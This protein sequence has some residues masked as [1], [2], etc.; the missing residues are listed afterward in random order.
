VFV[1]SLFLANSLCLG[2]KL[3][4]SHKTRALAYTE[5]AVSDL[6]PNPVFTSSNFD[7]CIK[8][9]IGQKPVL[10][11]WSISPAQPGARRNITFAAQFPTASGWMGLG[12]SASGSMIGAD[13]ITV[14][15]VGSSWIAEDRF[16]SAAELPQLDS[17]QDVMLVGASSAGGQSF[18]Q[19]VR[20]LVY[21]DGDLQDISVGDN[22]VP[23]ILAYGADGSYDFLYHGF[24]RRGSVWLNL[25]QKPSPT[26]SPPDGASIM[27]VRHTNL[28]V[29]QDDE[30]KYCYSA[31]VFP[32]DRKYHLLRAEA[33]LNSSHPELVHHM[34]IYSCVSEVS[35]QS[36]ADA[37]AP[38]T[39][40]TRMQLD[41]PVFWVMWAVGSGP[42]QLPDAAGLPMGLRTGGDV[43]TASHVVL[44]IHYTNPGRA[45]AIVD[46]SGFRL[47]Y[48]S[49]LRPNDAG[50]LTLGDVLFSIPP[51][52]TSFEVRQ[53]LYLRARACV[54]VLALEHLRNKR[55]RNSRM[56]DGDVQV[57]NM[58]LDRQVVMACV[59]GIPGLFCVLCASVRLSLH[60]HSKKQE[61]RGR[62]SKRAGGQKG[63][64]VS[65]SVLESEQAR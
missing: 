22:I 38:S 21:C 13:I 49:A 50:V 61:M 8:T 47:W 42:L 27:E 10:V 52:T 37:A 48:T 64:V 65:K 30:T 39:C 57:F 41:C 40:D 17:R 19:V 7:R 5:C 32:Q 25:M 59:C 35:A 51:Q 3:G 43:N 33:I 28:S 20:P 6:V 55:I 1:L 4:H 2:Q 14:R 26:P 56:E 62:W 44:E 15:R 46:S 31:H 12:L 63:Q 11:Y 9:N 34:I 53:C 58:A 36:Y 23:L 54:P 60:L 18:F 16:A 24:D 29:P 45:A